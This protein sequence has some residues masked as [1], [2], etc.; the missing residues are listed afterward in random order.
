M[1]WSSSMFKIQRH[2]NLALFFLLFVGGLLM[3]LIDWT[4]PFPTP[5]RGGFTMWW[6]IVVG[7]GVWFYIKSTRLPI[8]ETLELAS[9][10][11]GEL[12][13]D[14]LTREFGISVSIAKKT[15]DELQ[16]RSLTETSERGNAIV[17]VFRDHVSRNLPLE[18]V[19]L[20]A[21]N[22]KGK[23]TLADVIEQQSIT[24]TEAEVTLAKLVEKGQ[25]RVVNEEDGGTHWIFPS[26]VEGPGEV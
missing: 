16:R 22:A 15:L 13:L 1:A 4:T 26:L 19:L 23:L 18:N 17:W 20:Q 25:A 12:T 8:E 5:A 6:L 21:K 11:R 24:M 7:W 10:K 9:S 3:L 14:D 2:K